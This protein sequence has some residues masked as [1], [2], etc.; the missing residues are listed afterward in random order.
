MMENYKYSSCSLTTIGYCLS[1]I[2]NNEADIKPNNPDVIESI[3]HGDNKCDDI[4]T[5]IN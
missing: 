3:L 5:I 2:A 1:K 4:L